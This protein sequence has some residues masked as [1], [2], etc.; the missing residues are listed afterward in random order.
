M[1]DHFR[2][3][4]ITRRQTGCQLEDHPERMDSCI[5]LN[6]ELA[7]T[8]RHGSRELKVFPCLSAEV[9]QCLSSNYSKNL[10]D[11]NWPPLQGTIWS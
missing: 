9:K 11:L 3:Y 4:I 6:P 5:D 7:C 2:V 10:K 8:P 1:L